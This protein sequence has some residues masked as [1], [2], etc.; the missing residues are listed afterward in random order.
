M[1]NVLC[2]EPCCVQVCMLWCCWQ[3]VFCDGRVIGSEHL[4][5]CS[6]AGVGRRTQQDAA[7]HARARST[8]RLSLLEQLHPL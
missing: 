7:Q 1:S 5:V 3:L 6:A 4:T 8:R 2:F